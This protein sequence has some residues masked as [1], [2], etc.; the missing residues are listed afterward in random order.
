LQGDEWAETFDAFIETVQGFIN[1]VRI[2]SSDT[3][4]FEVEFGIWRDS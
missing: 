2:A 4:A 3:G 1:T